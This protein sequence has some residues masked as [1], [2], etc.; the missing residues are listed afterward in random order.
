MATHF[1]G[2][3][4]ICPVCWMTCGWNE[5]RQ[6]YDAVEVASEHERTKQYAHRSCMDK[7]RDNA[8]EVVPLRIHGKE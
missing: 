8:N 7:E 4:F 3:S 5:K 1:D 6:I 2:V